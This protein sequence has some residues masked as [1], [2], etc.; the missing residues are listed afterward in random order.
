MKLWPLIADWVD[1]E[2]SGCVDLGLSVTEANGLAVRFLDGLRSSTASPLSARDLEPDVLYAA[3]EILRKQCV[4]EPAKTLE[5]ST[6]ISEFLKS[7]PWAED[8]LGE[9][10]ELVCSYSFV[11]WRASRL[12]DRPHE[13]YRWETEYRSSLRSSLEWGSGWNRFLPRPAED[14]GGPRSHLEAEEAFR[15]VMFLQDNCDAVPERVGSS[16]V[17]LYRVLVSARGAQPA[18]IAP[19]LAGSIARI[20]GAAMRQSGVPEEA[21]EWLDIAEREFRGSLC[22]RAELAK[23]AYQRLALLYR[24]SRF[25]LVEAAIPTVDSS[26]IDLGMHEDHVKCRVLWAASLK[27]GG[28]YERALEVLEPLRGK[29]DQIPP[30]LYGWILLEFGDLHQ[31][32][33]DYERG[34]AEL[35]EA[36]ELLRNNNHFT[37]LAEVMAMLGSAYRAQGLLSEAIDLFQRGRQAYANLGMKSLEAYIRILLAETYLTR[38]NLA[39]AEREILAAFPTLQEQ[40]MLAEATAG[41]SLLREVARRRRGDGYR[42]S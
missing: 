28:R 1:Q 11:S 8:E 29:R 26:F 24:L 21:G 41:L 12:L 27:I 32:G 4:A 19:F 7:G 15:A 36:A 23:V 38:G 37:G 10:G 9:R 2:K 3:L 6:R 33:G 42:D 16:A 25:D 18:D 20:A 34:I 31:I 22:A 30:A 5:Q 14:T 35:T 13:K 17:D 39:D 40:R